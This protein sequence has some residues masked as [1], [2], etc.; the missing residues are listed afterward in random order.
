MSLLCLHY[1]VDNY[2]QEW[3][4]ITRAGKE[5]EHL[6]WLT[7]ISSI[8]ITHSLLI[9]LHIN[10]GNLAPSMVKIRASQSKFKNFCRLNMFNK[11]TFFEIHCFGLRYL[12]KVWMRQSEKLGV[13][14]KIALVGSFNQCLDQTKEAIHGLLSDSKIKNID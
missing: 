1:M 5:E 6:M 9:Y 2:R 14:N 11:R 3:D 12:F 10:Q 4:R 7:A 13:E 8:N